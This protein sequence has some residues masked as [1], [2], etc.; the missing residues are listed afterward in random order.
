MN[1]IRKAVCYILAIIFVTCGIGS[2]VFL[3]ENL[4]ILNLMQIIVAFIVLVIFFV[5]SYFMEVCRKELQ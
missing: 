3:A 1:T 5:A 2:L 4:P